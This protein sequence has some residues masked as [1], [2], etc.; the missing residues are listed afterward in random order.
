MAQ[1]GF[2]FM[3]ILPPQFPRVVGLE[4]YATVPGWML[5]PAVPRIGYKG[6]EG[7]AASAPAIRCPEVSVLP[8]SAPVGRAAEEGGHHLCGGRLQGS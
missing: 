3:V 5:T 2:G 4:V 7:L 8:T 1:A 6:R